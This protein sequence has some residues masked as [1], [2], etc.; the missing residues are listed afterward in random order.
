MLCPAFRL[1]RARL[2]AGRRDPSPGSNRLAPGANRFG[3]RRLG[4]GKRPAIAGHASGACVS[5][6]RLRAPRVWARPGAR[7]RMAAPG[8]D[9]LRGR[10]RPVPGTVSALAAAALGAGVR[11]APREQQSGACTKHAAP[12]APRVRLVRARALEVGQILGV[13]AGGKGAGFSRRRGLNSSGCGFQIA[14][15]LHLARALALIS[16]RRI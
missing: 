16:T 12:R 9:S 8:G 5:T 7:S 2:G 3:E 4:A 15:R 1:L 14:P 10:N 13:S 11:L 6:R